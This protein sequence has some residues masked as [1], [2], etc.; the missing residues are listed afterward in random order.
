MNASDRAALAAVP[1]PPEPLIRKPGPPVKPGLGQASRRVGGERRSTAVK[2]LTRTELDA[3]LRLV[4][5]ATC[6][7]HVTVAGLSKPVCIRKGDD[8]EAILAAVRDLL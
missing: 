3:Q 8:R 6:A 7:E 1:V 4:P 5:H 2:P